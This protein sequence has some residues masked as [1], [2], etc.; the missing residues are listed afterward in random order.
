MARNAV[1]VDYAN[2]K[3]LVPL[4]FEWKGIQ[5][6]ADLR[7]TAPVPVDEASAA[8]REFFLLSGLVGSELEGRVLEEDL[9]VNAVSTVELLRLASDRGVEIREIERS[10]VDVELAA[11][12]LEPELEATI[13]SHAHLGHVIQAPVSELSYRAWTGAG[14]SAWNPTTGESA[15]MLSGRIAGGSTVEPPAEF[16]EDILDALRDPGEP[17]SER[18]FVVGAIE[19]IDSTNFQETLVDREALFAL[20]VLVTDEEGNEVSD[21]VP[22][23]FTAVNAGSTLASEDLVE[24]GASITVPTLNGRARARLRVGTTTRDS[25]R[26][27]R[28]NPGDRYLTQ[29]GRYHVTVE[30]G[31]VVVED[32]FVAFALPDPEADSLGR[33]GRLQLVW[34]RYSESLP[35]VNDNIPMWVEVLDRFE[36]PL[37]NMPV[38]WDVQDAER[39]A[40][41]GEPLPDVFQNATIWDEDTEEFVE[42]YQ[43]L[44]SYLGSRAWIKLGDVDAT[45]YRVDAT[46]A[47]TK[48]PGGPIDFLRDARGLGSHLL[49]GPIGELLIVLSA[50]KGIDLKNGSI[51]YEE[52][53]RTF[54]TSSLTMGPV[55]GLLPVT[56]GFTVAGYQESY[57]PVVDTRGKWVLRGTG[58]F[59]RRDITDATVRPRLRQGDG[60]FLPSVLTQSNAP[61][62]AEY[63]F[64]FLFGAEP[65]LRRS[66][67]TVEAMVNRP[68]VNSDTGEV[69]VSQ[70]S[71]SD[72]DREEDGTQSM[73][74]GVSARMLPQDP[75]PFLLD[76][77]GHLQPGATIGFEIPP[78]AVD[79]ALSRETL[80]RVLEI[81]ENGKR[82]GFGALP[83]ATPLSLNSVLGYDSKNVYQARLALL[84]G[85]TMELVTEPAQLQFFNAF[86][87]SSNPRP[88]LVQDVPDL[89]NPGE[90]KL[91]TEDDA[92]LEYF[93][94][95]TQLP[96]EA[97]AVEL[98]EVDR[99]DVPAAVEFGR[100][101]AAPVNT[102]RQQ[103]HRCQEI[104][105][106]F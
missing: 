52:G 61:N 24:E 37:S 12:D 33:H 10:N 14:F 104:S 40:S 63:E 8:R 74:F 102:L 32:P 47:D 105:V 45:P 62:S 72:G 49:E 78:S 69:T 59:T 70:R 48:Y 15:Y 95:P 53:F 42:Q 98:Y 93:V 82:F 38:N 91:V 85:T 22:V 88:I 51:V 50:D 27:L 35:L 26:F 18:S 100:V 25:P 60:A 2:G 58:R 34:G 96:I 83:A 11:I 79:E 46:T 6:D 73:L 106:C 80:A 17:I 5:I 66:G 28:V 31:G 84:S 55:G 43:E 4:T 92:L 76:G 13:A 103:P 1:K 41:V 65:G 77:S 71:A 68:S 64:A 16:V 67:Y 75:D 99:G 101:A 23:T 29:V 94:R 21:G 7:P 57:E 89:E 20:K 97:A 90:F 3:E 9:A 54:V 86:M 36:N 30:A 19:K 39:F 87:K 44:T 81:S 56:V